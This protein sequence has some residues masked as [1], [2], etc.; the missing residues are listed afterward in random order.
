MMITIHLLTLQGYQTEVGENAGTLSGG[1]RQRIAI[2]R[3]IISNPRILLL[4]E[5]TS[6]LD[7]NAEKAVQDALDNISVGRTTVIIA[8]K[9]STVKNA[10]N[11]AVISDGTV[12]EQG[13]HN[14]LLHLNGHY[15]RL[16]AA[17]DLGYTDT[18]EGNPQHDLRTISGP[19]PSHEAKELSPKENFQTEQGTLG[20]S[21]VRC[22]WIILSEQRPI[23]PAMFLAIVASFVGAATFPGQAL[24]YSRVLTV[25][26]LPEEEGRRQ[27]NFYALMFF[28]VA[29]G[30]LLAYCTIGATCNIIGQQLTY[31]Y[32]SEML[33]NIIRQD[34]EF[35][36][37]PEN[38]S[39][40]LTAKITSIPSSIQE[41]ISINLLLIVIVLI[42]IVSSS[43]LAIAYGWKLGLVTIFSG[44]PA[45]IAAG[46][47]RV[48]IETNLEKRNSAQFSKSASLASESVL[49]IKTVSS[50][51]LEPLI[52]Q[53]YSDL[54][55]GIVKVT[56]RSLQWNLCLYALSQSFEFLIMALGLWYGST[57]ISSGEYTVT[58]FYIIFLGVLFASQAAG[59]FFSYTSGK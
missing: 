26:M 30:N 4:D 32:R 22:I 29:L 18:A 24:L 46:Y 23:Y 1:Q 21:L 42:N 34:I 13:N 3:S 40:A 11:I 57:L 50:L 54:L 17:Q 43:V 48:R 53:R 10:D 25:F 8:H 59:Q 7:P 9:L 33:R 12:S 52:L 36:D 28:V 19:P 35:F 20:Y 15:A 5:A 6:A 58:Q 41:L 47:A 38:T 56:I 16:V 37:R 51:T 44:F 55:S 27:V 49:A 2:A 39:G 31:S 45:L 14:E